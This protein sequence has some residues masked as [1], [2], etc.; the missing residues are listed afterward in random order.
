MEMKTGPE[1]FSKKTFCFPYNLKVSIPNIAAI[2][3]G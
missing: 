1:K 2:S 3:Q